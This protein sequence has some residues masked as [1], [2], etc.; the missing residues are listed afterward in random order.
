MPGRI[1]KK[2][3]SKS[4]RSIE[5]AQAGMGMGCT[6]VVERVLASVGKLSEVSSIFKASLDVSNA[7]VLWS[8]PALLSNGL[9]LHSKDN[10]SLPKG[11]YGLTHIFI[12]LAFMALT[13]IK[14][15]EELRYSPAGELGLLLGLD[16]IPEVRTLRGKIKHLCEAGQVEQWSSLVSKEWM[17]SSEEPAGTL[18]VDGHVRVYHG[19]QTKLPRR[20]VSRE[21][22]CMRGMTDYWVNDQEGRPFFVVSTPFTIGL[23]EMLR[24]EIAPRLLKDISSQPTDKELESDPDLARFTLVFDR[25]GYSPEFFNEMWRKW[26]IACITYNKYPKEDWPVEEFDEQSLKLPNG[27]SITMKIVERGSHIGGKKKGLW[28]RQIRKLSES[29]HQTSVISTEFKAKSTDLGLRMF[30]RWSQENFFKYMT[31]HFNIDA[32]T[33]YKP[34]NVNETK[35]VVNPEY[36]KIEWEIKSKG[37]K[38]GRRMKQFAEMRLNEAPKPD[39]IEEY[40]RKKGELVEDIA[41]LK[42]DL[43]EFKEKR[44]MTNK[45]IPFAELP[46]T[47]RFSQLGTVRKQFT[48]TIKMIAYRAETAMAGI[49]RESLGHVDNARS[50]LREI[51]T[52]DA[53]IVPNEK[54]H[55]LTVRLHHLTN[56]LSDKAACAL[57]AH[58]NETET[59]YPGTDLRLCYELVSN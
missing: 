21:R 27:E 49:I 6:R 59:I 33:S 29:G 7:G 37:A 51:Y 9:L 10:F 2:P 16:R 42:K 39:E 46:E 34:E 24:S 30:G 57:A 26:R 20:Y 58:L 22:L 52:T 44:K 1:K 54:E 18:Y 50:L 31:Q 35:Q 41:R 43:E 40:E 56:H 55:T 19:S 38:H 13:R 11:F 53:D 12:L 4:E 14:A 25:E 17:E 15:I 8:L 36:R 28:V 5:D 23:L 47:D 3:E 32:L 45:H 48:D